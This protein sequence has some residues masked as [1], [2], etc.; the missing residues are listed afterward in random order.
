MKKAE[1]FTS[2]GL[3][4]YYFLQSMVNRYTAKVIVLS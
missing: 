4:D 2:L 1:A 3:R